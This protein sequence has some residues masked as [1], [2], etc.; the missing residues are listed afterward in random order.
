M[1]LKMKA[2]S[3]GNQLIL[4]GTY[5]GTL[6]R[7]EEA[8]NT[9]GS[10]LKWTFSISY[11]GEARIITGVSPMNLDAGSKSRF[12]TEALLGRPLR[13]QEEI[14]LEQLYGRPC[15]IE[16]TTIEKDGKSYNRIV[17]VTRCGGP[18]QKTNDPAQA[19]AE[20]E[21]EPADPTPF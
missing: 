7:V 13:D 6:T 3:S 18:V 4:G 21:K 12:W 2:V 9:D 14:D 11:N 15:R 1:S 5:D 20:P 17:K 10:Y 8:R 16:V 19:A